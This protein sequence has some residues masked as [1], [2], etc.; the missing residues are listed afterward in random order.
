MRCRK[1]SVRSTGE[2][3]RA[4]SRC[5]SSWTGSRVRSSCDVVWA[6]GGNLAP[7]PWNA[8]QLFEAQLITF[9]DH[10]DHPEADR[11]L[12]LDCETR[13]HPCRGGPPEFQPARRVLAHQG[14]G[15]RAQH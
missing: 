5:D 7:V 10:A 11:S 12:L 1:L 9:A 3:R 6:M 15:G 14:T 2:S 13:K 8:K 4:T